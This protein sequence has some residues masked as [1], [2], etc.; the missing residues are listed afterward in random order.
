MSAQLLANHHA[1]VQAMQPYPHAR[2]IVVSKHQP[3]ETLIP[4]LDAGQRHF[5]ENRVQEAA[6]KWPSLRA[7][8]PDIQLHLIGQ[9]QRNKAAQAA[10]LFDSIHSLDRIALADAL[11]A[12]NYRGQLLI[13]VNLADEPQKGGVA[14]ADLPALLH[15]SQ[16]R[17]GLQISGLMTVPPVGDDPAPHFR[18][19]AGLARA[20]QLPEL[21]MGMS[22]DYQQALAFGATYIRVGSAIFA[23]SAHQIK[24]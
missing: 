6:E 11:A 3:A 5:G 9:L 20:H 24:E 14:V 2:L 8:Y 16:Q 4:L 13:Q 10:A 18:Q 7:R 23:C 1:V 21:S 12:A 17:C 19:L 15:H 22:G